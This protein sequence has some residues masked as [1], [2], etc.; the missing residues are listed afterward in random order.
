MDQLLL[1]I[2]SLLKQAVLTLK[3]SRMS[4]STMGRIMTVA[5][6]LDTHIDRN[7]VV[8]M[9]PNISLEGIKSK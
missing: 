1:K 2:S 8:I 4:T 6:V 7:M 3:S 5:P 9:I